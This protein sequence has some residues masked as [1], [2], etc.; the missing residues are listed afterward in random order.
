MSSISN[1]S[2]QTAPR[3][4]VKY[5]EAV[6][7]LEACLTLQ[8]A[9]YWTNTA[10]ALAAWSKIYN[11]DEAESNAR[12]L[13]LHAYRRMSQLADQLGREPANQSE[14]AKPPKREGGHRNIRSG[15]GKGPAAVLREHGLK[16][17]QIGEI[18]RIGRIPER[19]FKELVAQN[20]PPAIA[21]AATAGV[22]RKHAVRQAETW[23][24]LM[25]RNGHGVNLASFVAF[26]QRYPPHLVR[27]LTDEEVARIRSN[28]TFIQE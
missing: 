9:R 22:S 3:V 11:D 18:T 5:T 19:R 25:G 8:E 21:R 14:V 10:D 27:S 24:P 17:N 23:L 12:R 7:A 6:K 28:M 26:T 13:K 15:Q 4:P 16:S 1:I 2:E 20:R